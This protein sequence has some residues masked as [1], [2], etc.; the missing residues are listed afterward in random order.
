M[1]E[2]E[3]R[4]LAD[5][6]TRWNSDILKVDS[7]L[8]HQV[9]PKL[10]AQMGKEIKRLYEDSG[11]TKILTIESSGIAIA[12]FAALE[13]GIPF[14]FAKK[15]NARNLDDNAYVAQVYSFTKMVTYTIKVSKDYLLPEDR[16]LIVDDFLAN[17]KAL[18]GLISIVE[19]AGASVVGCAI[20]IEKAYQHGGD[21]VRSLGYR[22][23][24][25]ATVKEINSEGKVIF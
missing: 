3:E 22:V 2:L 11:A 1:K 21:R 4:I 25:L 10:M 16:V 17:G 12:A 8:N 20:A 6:E 13:M 24:A 9:D 5:G 23:D 18:E 14:V 15:Y 19:A 7:F